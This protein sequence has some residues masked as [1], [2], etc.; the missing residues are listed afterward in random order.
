[1]SEMGNEQHNFLLNFGAYILVIPYIVLV[2]LKYLLS[3]LIVKFV[4]KFY[5]FDHSKPHTSAIV[6]I[7]NASNRSYLHLNKSLF[8][9]FLMRVGIEL[10]LDFCL[11]S[12]ISFYSLAPPDWQ[13]GDMLGVYCTFA[14]S[15]SVVLL[16]CVC[17]Y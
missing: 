11:L 8:W 7:M 1:M 3:F 17:F 12:L 14:A 10:Y 9:S 6:K 15:L 5:K 4:P 16:S 13:L 2:L